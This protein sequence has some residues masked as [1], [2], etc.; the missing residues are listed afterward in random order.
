[1]ILVALLMA[2][3]A[4]TGERLFAQNCSVGYCHGVGGAA[5][6]GPRLRGRGFEESYLLGVVRNGIPHSAMPAWKGRLSDADILAVVRYVES[7][8]GGAGEQT[9]ATVPEVRAA[10][11]KIPPD[12]ERG[13]EVFFDATR[14]TPCSTC[15]ELDARG[16]AVGPDLSKLGKM[17][18]R[19]IAAALRLEQPSH[20]VAIRTT[21]GESIPALVVSE[22][23]SFVKLYDLGAALPVLRTLALSQIQSRE[24][25]PS[26]SHSPYLKGIDPAQMADLIAYL[27]WKA[28]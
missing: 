26:W 24:A 27:R 3:S 14:D 20:L 10:P 21:G 16:T 9:H 2:Q 5:G 22:D 4:V 12:V 23:E 1:M 18:P 25:I 17:T 8:S 15:H 6:R 19:D 7:L 11:V 13:R 28:R